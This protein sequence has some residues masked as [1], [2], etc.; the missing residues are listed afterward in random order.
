MARRIAASDYTSANQFGVDRRYYDDS[1]PG[2][3]HN[4]VPYA[5]TNGGTLT[6]TAAYPTS[7]CP[8]SGF[9]VCLTDAQLATQLSSYLAA[10]PTLPKGLAP[11]TSS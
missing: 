11:S 4:F 5:V 10:H 9:S 2:G 8:L 1:G 7:G 6:D 3:T